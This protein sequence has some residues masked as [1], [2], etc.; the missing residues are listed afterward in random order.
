MFECSI[1][2]IFLGTPLTGLTVAK[3][4]LT[5]CMDFAMVQPLAQVKGNLKDFQGF[6]CFFVLLST[7][8]GSQSFF[9]KLNVFGDLCASV[10]IHTSPF[11]VR[12]LAKSCDFHIF[13]TDFRRFRSLIRSPSVVAILQTNNHFYSPIKQITVVR[14]HKLLLSYPLLNF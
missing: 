11:R 6:R 9:R 10:R 8:I 2:R 3:L 13:P 7:K 4:D 14:V 1:D 5:K 12:F